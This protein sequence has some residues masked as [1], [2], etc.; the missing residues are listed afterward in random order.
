[1]HLIRSIGVKCYRVLRK[2]FRVY[3]FLLSS[4]STPSLIFFGKNTICQQVGCQQGDPCGSLSFSET[5]HQMA[6]EMKSE[7]VTHGI[8]TTVPS[9][10]IL[11]LSSMISN[12]LLRKQK[13]WVLKS[14]RINANC[15]FCFWCVIDKTI[16]DQFNKISPGIEITAKNKLEILGVPIFENG[17]V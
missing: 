16:V 13:D 9:A 2:I 12:W 4:Y 7:V 15:F 6:S 3:Q 5:I 10:M 14:I 1:M 17:Y 8:W 11:Q